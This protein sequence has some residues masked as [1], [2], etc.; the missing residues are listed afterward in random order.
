MNCFSRRQVFF[1]AVLLAAILLGGTRHCVADPPDQADF[2]FAFAKIGDEGKLQ[3]TMAWPKPQPAA[4]GDDGEIEMK[5]E[6]YEVEVPAV[7]VVPQTYTVKVPYTEQVVEDGKQTT[8]TRFREETRTRN[9][10]V[11]VMA[12]QLRTRVVPVE[13]DRPEF[14]VATEDIQCSTLAGDA[15]PW[16]AAKEKLAKRHPVLLLPEDAELV[17]Q[18]QAFL[19]EDVM[20]LRRISKP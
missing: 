2:K 12:K 11:T 20:V 6:T 5:Q 15:I 3:I 18:L 8:V 17:P 10:N 1:S 9:V 13:K 4:A 14:I 19:Q 7:R 16:T